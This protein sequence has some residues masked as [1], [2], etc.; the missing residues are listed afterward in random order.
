M[1]D[2]SLPNTLMSGTL[3]EGGGQKWYSMHGKFIATDQNILLSAN[4]I[5]KEQWDVYLSI[6]NEKEKE[7][8]LER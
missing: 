7:N 1:G 4:L 3:A 5:D 6:Y 8:L 2:P